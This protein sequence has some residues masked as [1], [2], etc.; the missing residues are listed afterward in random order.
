MWGW[1]GGWVLGFQHTNLGEAGRHKHSDHSKEEVY[2]RDMGA[3]H[4]EPCGGESCTAK[5]SRARGSHSF[6]LSGVISFLI[7][8]FLACLL[9]L[10][11]TNHLSISHKNHRAYNGQGGPASYSLEALFQ[12]G[13][14]DFWLVTGHSLPV[15]LGFSSFLGTCYSQSW[16]DSTVH[17]TLLVWE[18]PNE[19]EEHKE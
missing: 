8:P 11:A 12:I 10:L 18:V 3:K 6:H 17:Q 2:W 7:A 4:R 1:G 5:L 19:G 9:L 13:S 16:L 14:E 15:I